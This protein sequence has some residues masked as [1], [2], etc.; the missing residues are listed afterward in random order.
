MTNYEKAEYYRLHTEAWLLF[1]ESY[2]KSTNAIL[3]CRSLIVDM[4]SE[5]IKASI[6]NPK[7][8]KLNA[9]QNRIDLLSENLDILEILNNRCATQQKQLREYKKKIFELEAELKEI[10]RQEREGLEV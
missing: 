2:N 6:S 5:I 3:N 7:N 9:S 4:Q 10:R 8:S 1:Y